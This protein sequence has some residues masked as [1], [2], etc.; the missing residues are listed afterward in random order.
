[1]NRFDVIR[2]WADSKRI[3]QD[4]SFDDRVTKT[5]SAF[6]RIIEHTAHNN[7]GKLLEA[8]GAQVI[9]LTLLCAQLG[10]PIEDAIEDAW[11]KY[12]DNDSHKIT[13]PTELF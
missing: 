7:R 6:G 4:G 12:P 2:A 3:T 13:H 8:I 11:N 1:M 10:L 9:E 5:V